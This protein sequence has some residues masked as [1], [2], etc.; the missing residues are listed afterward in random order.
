MYFGAEDA[1]K[2]ND[3]YRDQREFIKVD[4]GNEVEN[5]VAISWVIDFFQQYNMHSFCFA[6][7][8][9]NNSIVQ[10]LVKYGYQG[11]PIAQGVTGIAAATE[12][13]EKLLRAGK[14]EHFGHPILKYQNSHCLAVR[15]EA[16]TRIEKNGKVLGIYACLNA[17][18]QWKLIDGGDT[19]DKL[20]Q[21]W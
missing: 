14:V 17:L 4:P 3:F 12:E 10:G 21:S 13:W 6:N 1:V 5:E 20:I 18:A 19:D 9:K 15:K 16:G 7:T 11:Q 2:L 8:Q